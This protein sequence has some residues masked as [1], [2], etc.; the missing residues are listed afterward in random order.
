MGYDQSLRSLHSVRLKPDKH[1]RRCPDD[2][3]NFVSMLKPLLHYQQHAPVVTLSD[4]IL[5]EKY[6]MLVLCSDG[7]WGPLDD[8]IIVETLTTG[9]I[10]QAV[11]SMAEQ[12]ESKSYPE[13]DNVSVIAFRWISSESDEK[14]DQPNQETA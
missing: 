4:K 1:Q 14:L 9:T 12:A 8:E 3:G 13:S 11:E 5:L 6:D 2:S 7:L 10:T